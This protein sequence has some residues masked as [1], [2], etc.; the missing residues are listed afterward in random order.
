MLRREATRNLM[1]TRERSGRINGPPRMA[2]TISEP[3]LPERS[4]RSPERDQWAARRVGTPGKEPKIPGKGSRSPV[5]D[6]SRA[7]GKETDCVCVCVCVCVRDC[8]WV[9]VCIC[10]I[11]RREGPEPTHCGI[12]SARGEPSSGRKELPERGAEERDL[13]PWERIRTDLSGGRH[14]LSRG[15]ALQRK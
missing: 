1:Q 13:D 8:V 15:R 12:T 7:P 9:C 14:Y 11:P 4:R 6:Q 3:E 2:C 10:V 5:R